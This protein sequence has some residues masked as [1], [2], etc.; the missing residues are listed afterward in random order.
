MSAPQRTKGMPEIFRGLVA[1]VLRDSLSWGSHWVRHRVAILWPLHAMH[2]AQ[3]QMNPYL[4]HRDHPLDDLIDASL[5][6]IPAFALGLHITG[7][8]ALA[9]F[10]IWYPMICHANLRSDFGV[11]RFLLVTPQSHRMHHATTD[12]GIVR[13]GRRR[14]R[15]SCGC[16]HLRSC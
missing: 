6:G 13:W 14:Y 12:E 8:T 16:P 1:L 4:S 15:R 11:L 5:T 10:A 7:A 3:R 2:H 9:V